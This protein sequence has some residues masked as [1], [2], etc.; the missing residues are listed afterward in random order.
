MVA[1]CFI[2]DKVYLQYTKYLHYPLLKMFAHDE[3]GLLLNSFLIYKRILL[4]LI[5]YITLPI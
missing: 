1:F 5:L 4:Y 2:N 3:Y